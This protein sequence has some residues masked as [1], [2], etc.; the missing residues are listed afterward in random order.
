MFVDTRLNVCATVAYIHVEAISGDGKTEYHA[1][2]TLTWK[3]INMG[4]F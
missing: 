4:L 1:P 3:L 2:F